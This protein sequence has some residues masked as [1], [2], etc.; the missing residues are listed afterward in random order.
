MHDVIC[1]NLYHSK[2]ELNPQ[3]TGVAG[4]SPTI[5]IER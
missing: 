2:S 3:K 1:V 5:Q 4:A